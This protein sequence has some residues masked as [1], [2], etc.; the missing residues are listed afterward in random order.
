[1]PQAHHEAE[2][3]G[4]IAHLLSAAQAAYAAAHP[5]QMDIVAAAASIA[6]N[7]HRGQTDK[8]GLDYFEGHLTTVALKGRDWKE[9]TTGFLHDA[10]EDTGHTTREVMAMLKAKAK[11]ITAFVP[12]ECDWMEIETALE[13]LNSHTATSREAYIGRMGHSMLACTV[14]ASDLEHNM[15]ITR[16]P[17]PT[18]KDR[19]R[20]ARY[21]TE[22][23]QIRA[24][25]AKRQMENVV[26]T[27]GRQP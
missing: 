15:D 20:L 24:F 22:Y 9:M 23:A 6:K 18:A 12:Q 3:A 1:M 4:Y 21:K 11:P 27:S 13:L 2:T 17:H 14:K 19:R 7:L 10:A 5:G 25:I 26:A 16:L 8:A